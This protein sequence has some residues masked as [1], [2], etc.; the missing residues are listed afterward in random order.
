MRRAGSLNEM[1]PRASTRSTAGAGFR[2]A[3]V[4]VG[5]DSVKTGAVPI[6][7]PLMDVIAHMKQPIAIGTSFRHA[8]RAAPFALIA[9]QRLRRFIAPRVLQIVVSPAAGLFPF[10]LER[11]P[12]GFV[13]DMR[14]PLAVR[15]G[16]E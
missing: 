15:H 4:F 12:I 16:I 2:A 1:A 3:R 8:L 5:R 13:G 6:E 9:L 7:T 11:Q 10:G 14:E